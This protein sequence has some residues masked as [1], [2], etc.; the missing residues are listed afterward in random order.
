[1]SDETNYELLSAYIDG[2]L[3]PVER[4]RVERLISENAEC[5]QVYEEL[6]ALR[7]SLSSLPRHKVGEDLAARV[8]RL[9]EEARLAGRAARGGA[10]IVPAGAQ[11][12]TRRAAPSWRAIVYP[13]LA[14]RCRGDRHVGHTVERQGKAGAGC[15]PSPGEARSAG[16]HVGGTGKIRREARAHV[17]Q[18]PTC[19]QIGGRIRGRGRIGSRYVGS[20]SRSQRNALRHDKR[21]AKS[22]KSGSGASGPEALKKER[23]RSG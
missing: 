17:C 20:K 15:R 22:L 23:L 14:R 3:P 6:C 18:R 19:Q 21:L 10:E 16:C 5:R 2:E 13:A 8:L 7:A 1:M 11:P 12:T 9:A 4:Q